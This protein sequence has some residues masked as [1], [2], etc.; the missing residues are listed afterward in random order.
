M[1]DIWNILCNENMCVCMYEYYNESEPVYSY[2]NTM[3]LL[4]ENFILL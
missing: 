4:L 3:G 2:S 1:F